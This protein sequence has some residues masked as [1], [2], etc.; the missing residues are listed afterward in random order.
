MNWT[1][2][3][4]R[5]TKNLRKSKDRAVVFDQGRRRLFHPIP[6]PLLFKRWGS[7]SQRSNSSKPI[8]AFTLSYYCDLFHTQI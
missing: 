3:G 4:Y 6:L 7:T 8:S 2:A 1:C 5:K